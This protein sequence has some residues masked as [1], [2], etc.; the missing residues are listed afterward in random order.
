MLLEYTSESTGMEVQAVDLLLW[1]LEV[2]VGEKG[3]EGNVGPF[4]YVA[5]VP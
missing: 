3:E 5:P 2:Y 4:A 1:L